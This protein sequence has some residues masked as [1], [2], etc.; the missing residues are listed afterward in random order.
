MCKELPCTKWASLLP[1][2]FYIDRF[3]EVGNPR[4][5]S[6]HEVHQCTKWTFLWSH[7]QAIIACPLD[8]TLLEIRY[9]GGTVSEVL[10]EAVSHVVVDERWACIGVFLHCTS[11]THL[12]HLDPHCS[13]S[14]PR[15][16]SDLSRLSV[17]RALERGHTKKH[18]FVTSAWVEA[19]LREQALLS[20]RGY[21]PQDPCS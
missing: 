12:Q 16:H 20:E 8:L 19:C 7:P 11:L 13:L 10:D 5:V 14:P 9:H 2:R 15:T 6:W 4:A 21:E 3:N 18:H 1:C 17:L